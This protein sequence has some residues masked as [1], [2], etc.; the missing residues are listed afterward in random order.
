MYAERIVERGAV[1]R[2]F[3]P[4]GHALH[5]RATRLTAARLDSRKPTGRGRRQSAVDAL[6]TDGLPVAARC[7][8]AEQAC[9]DGEPTLEAV[10][11]DSPHP[12]RGRLHPRDEIRDESK[13]YEDIC[14]ARSRHPAI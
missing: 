5:H 10:K 1:E 9:L 4:L 11:S 6:R 12:A 8:V 2:N 3:L 14:E 7:P 13:H